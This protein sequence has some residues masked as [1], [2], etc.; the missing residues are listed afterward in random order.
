MTLERRAWRT[1]RERHPHLA[2]NRRH[3]RII[4]GVSI[5]TVVSCSRLGA[6][7]LALVLWGDIRVLDACCARRWLVSHARRA[8]RVD[9][10][11]PHAG[12]TTDR[13]V[14]Y[15]N[16]KK[17]RVRGESLHTN[18]L[19]CL[20]RA[21][22]SQL[23]SIG[24]VGPPCVASSPSLHVQVASYLR[25]AESNSARNCRKGGGCSQSM[26]QLNVLASWLATLLWAAPACSFGIF[27]P[28]NLFANETSLTEDVLRH[29]YRWRNRQ[30]FLTYAIAP[31]FC[32][33]I[34]PLLHAEK[35]QW[36]AIMPWQT[37]VNFT[38]CERI[39]ALVHEAFATWQAASPALSF[40]DVS[41][42]CVAERMW[43]PVDEQECVLSPWCVK[44][45]NSTKGPD[46]APNPDY[47]DWTEEQTP[48]EMSKPPAER[49]THRTCWDC[50]RANVVVGAFTQKNRRLGDQHARSRVLRKDLKEM[51]PAGFDGL[52]KPGGIVERAMLQVNTD[53]A[54]MDNG[55][56][57]GTCWKLDS[58]VCDW[59]ASVHSDPTKS[60]YDLEN[61]IA[62][63]TWL[64]FALAIAC[65]TCSICFCLRRLSYNLLS[66]YDLD[67]DGKL[68]FQEITYVLDEFLGDLVCTCQCPNIKDQQ[69][70]ALV[71]GVTIL[72][73]LAFFPFL[74]MS[75]CFFAATA[76]LMLFSHEFSYC[77]TCWDLGAALHHEVGHL[78]SLHHPAI[79]VDKES[80][81]LVQLN[82]TGVDFYPPPMPPPDPYEGLIDDGCR[83][84]AL[85]AKSGTGGGGTGCAVSSFG[86]TA[87]TDDV[88]PPPPSPGPPPLSPAT[89][90]PSPPPISPPRPPPPLTPPLY[91]PNNVRHGDSW[92]PYFSSAPWC[93]PIEYSGYTLRHSAHPFGAEQPLHLM[94]RATQRSVNSSV[95]LAFDLVP[96]SRPYGPG[97][98]RRCLSA[99]DLD[100][101]NFLYPACEGTTFYGLLEPAPC[102]ETLGDWKATTL[103]LFFQ[104][105]DLTAIVVGCIIAVKLLAYLALK[106]EERMANAY[107]NSKAKD[108]LRYGSS[109]ISAE[110]HNLFNSI[111]NRKAMRRN[112]EERMALRMQ[113]ALRRRNARKKLQALR[114][115]KLQEIRNTHLAAAKLQGAIRGKWTRAEI[116]PI[117]SKKSRMFAVRHHQKKLRDRQLALQDKLTAQT[118]PTRAPAMLLDHSGDD[119]QPQ[120]TAL[121]VWPASFKRAPP[122]RVMPNA[123]GR[124]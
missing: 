5:P 113:K 21:V 102:K 92:Q 44:V 76:V 81:T 48:L 75:V 53:D 2:V 56:K 120:S 69:V 34:Q 6:T 39:H 91:P 121:V 22:E 80:L 61:D 78:L 100:G 28:K 103:R 19:N 110:S 123:A 46:Y 30:T 26:Q 70:N 82:T 25:T 97:R 64:S 35:T 65:C 57:L 4:M 118:E 90:P 86:Y 9:R 24:T 79:A 7:L 54:Y 66:G 59:I 36:T 108:M 42:R 67:N 20:F 77:F 114:D 50:K 43:L 8:R 99:D 10:R 55:T 13:V 23:T 31:D 38:S 18:G 60:N 117:G 52:A 107:A 51:R 96:T 104:T 87:S 40:V 119:M 106:M 62:F 93:R 63:F 11:E 58:D 88:S 84:R 41:S 89:P 16:D 112:M 32:E 73:T 111:F 115:E 105:F 1:C 83:R 27:S 47:V 12:T 124:R 94:T 116:G 122:A 15:A 98:A 72:E 33:S 71:G 109:V 68:S 29:T 85:K 45:E 3:R 17:V 37:R 14:C 74:F 101:V 49:C 95:M